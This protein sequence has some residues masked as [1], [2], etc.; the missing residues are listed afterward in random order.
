[1]YKFITQ[2]IAGVVVV[3]SKVVDWLLILHLHK[4]QTMYARSFA[5]S[6]KILLLCNETTYVTGSDFAKTGFPLALSADSGEGG[7]EGEGLHLSRPAQRG[8]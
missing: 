5:V 4:S 2:L 8:L 6:I 3:N 7:D 1:L